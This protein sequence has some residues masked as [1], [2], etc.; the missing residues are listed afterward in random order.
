[1]MGTKSGSSSSLSDSERG[2]SSPIVVLI[3]VAMFSLALT[4]YM[5]YSGSLLESAGSERALSEPTLER[6]WDEIAVAG[7]YDEDEE[8]TDAISKETLPEGRAV[9][10][11][12]QY[13]D[14]DR[15]Y[16]K[17]DSAKFEPDGSTPAS[18]LDPEKDPLPDGVETANRPIG[19]RYGPQDVK[20]AKLYVGV[21]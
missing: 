8:L 20:G 19:V 14:D 10:V 12:I 11:M 6:I 21:A 9:Y 5:G 18:N 17:V 16:K 7:A 13:V 4:M 3:S 2:T 15:T 1:M